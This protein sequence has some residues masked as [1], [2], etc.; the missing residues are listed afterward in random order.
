MQKL[1][2]HPLKMMPMQQCTCLHHNSSAK[3][4][5]NVLW[6]SSLL[7][8]QGRLAAATHLH[9][10]VT[11]NPSVCQKINPHNET[12]LWTGMVHPAMTYHKLHPPPLPGTSLFIHGGAKLWIMKHALTHILELHTKKWSKQPV[13]HCWHCMPGIR[14]CV[15]GC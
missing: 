1:P 13:P 12:G 3:A 9:Q 7:S 11:P 10:S 8:Q 4:C 5:H 14:D 2:W 15:L 6:P